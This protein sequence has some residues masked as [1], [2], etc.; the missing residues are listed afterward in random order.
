MKLRKIA[1]IPVYQ[2]YEMG[3][4]GLKLLRCGLLARA[5]LLVT[6]EIP[7]RIDCSKNIYMSLSLSNSSWAPVY[8]SPQSQ[9]RAG[10]ET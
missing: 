10:A 8:F 3:Q 7:P 2:I 1:Y 6:V 9:V 4:R 5:Y